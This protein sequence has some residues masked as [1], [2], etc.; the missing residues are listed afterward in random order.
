MKTIII[1]II[2]SLSCIV[3]RAN[4][5]VTVDKSGNYVSTSVST[6]DKDTVT[7]K[8]FTTKEGKKYSVYLSQRGKLYI[9]RVSKKGNT[10]KQYLQVK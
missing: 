10:Y 4:T 8:T 3:A 5:I 2:I 6:S 9:I 1:A 7:G